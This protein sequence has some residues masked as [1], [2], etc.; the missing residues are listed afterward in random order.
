[1]T[2]EYPRIEPK[3]SPPRPLSIEQQKEKESKLKHQRTSERVIASISEG[4]RLIAS[5]RAFIGDR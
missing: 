4:D 1:M 2:K 5:L 3:K